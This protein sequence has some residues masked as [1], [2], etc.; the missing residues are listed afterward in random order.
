ME[1]IISN[2]P[3]CEEHSLHLS[4]DKELSFM[5]CVNCGYVSSD[6]FLGTREDNEEYKKLDELLQKWVKETE[7][8]LW[9]PIQM[10]LPFGMI[11][12]ALVD[13]EMKWVFAEM[14]EIPEEEQKNYPIPNQEGK[15]YTQ[16]YETENPK[17]YDKYAFALQAVQEKLQ[18]ETQKAVDK[19]GGITTLKLPKLKKQK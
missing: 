5:Q 10:T 1:K 12:P 16:K 8:R 19:K 13:N 7:G 11:Y 17:M 4:N 14:I 9:I 18:S 6:N 3:L 15:F 2:C